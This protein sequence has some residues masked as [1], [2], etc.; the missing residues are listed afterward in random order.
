MSKEWHDVGMV[1]SEEV[2]GIPIYTRIFL[3]SWLLFFKNEKALTAFGIAPACDDVCLVG[4][5]WTA[6]WLITVMSVA[7]VRN[8]SGPTVV[9]LGNVANSSFGRGPCALQ[10]TWYNFCF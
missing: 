4:K 7:H 9:W 8:V 10:D 6:A 5:V 1:L 3:V 2:M